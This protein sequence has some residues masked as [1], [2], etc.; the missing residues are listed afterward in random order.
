[1]IYYE[2]LDMSIVEL[3]SKRLIKVTW[4]GPTLKDEVKA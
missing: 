2:K 1:M 4:L 3:E